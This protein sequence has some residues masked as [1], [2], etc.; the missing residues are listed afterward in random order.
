MKRV[1]AGAM[2]LLAITNAVA[3]RA[4]SIEGVWR[5]AQRITPA[6]HPRTGGIAVTQDNPQPNLLM[7]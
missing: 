4:P 2:C 5:I 7:E 3:Q 6:G 1:S